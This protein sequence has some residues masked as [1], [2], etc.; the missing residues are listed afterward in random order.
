MNTELAKAYSQIILAHEDWLMKRILK[1]AKKQGYAKYTSTLEEAW[2][3]SIQEMSAVISKNIDLDIETLELRPEDRFED[4]DAA[5]FGILEADRHR[6]RGTPLTMFLAFYKYYLQTYL[7]MVYTLDLP[8]EQEQDFTLRITRIFDKIE[9]GYLHK[10]TSLTDESAIV[11]LQESSLKLTNEKNMF[12]TLVESIQAPV[13]YLDETRQIKFMNSHAPEL[14]GGKA[15]LAGAHYVN[16]VIKHTIPEWLS[17][18]LKQ[19]KKSKETELNFE[20]EIHSQGSVCHFL[21]QI[22]KM[23]DVSGKFQ[24]YS[25]FAQDITDRKAAELH[26]LENEKTVSEIIQNML[27]GYLSIDL[28]GIITRVNASTCRLMGY[29]EE[30]MLGKR[31]RDIFYSDDEADRVGKELIDHGTLQDFKSEFKRK[32]GEVRSGESNFRLVMD[33]NGEPHHLESTF[34]DITERIQIE[35]ALLESKERLSLATSAGGIGIWDYD[36]VTGSVLWDRAMYRLYGLEPDDFAG[37]DEAWDNSVHP[38]D[39]KRADAAVQTSIKHGTKHDEEFRVIWPDGSIRVLHTHADVIKD[40]NG[41]S[42]RLL[43]VTWDITSVKDAERALSNKNALLNTAEKIGFVG[44]WEWTLATNEVFYSDNALK[45][46]GVHPDDYNG[47]MESI[48]N[49]VHP[50][51]QARLSASI[52]KMVTEKKS[53]RNEY[54]VIHK[55]GSIRVLIS[56]SILIFDSQGEVERLIGHIQDITEQKKATED[57]QRALDDRKKFFSILG[58]DLRGPMG[59]IVGLLEIVNEDFETMSSEEMKDIVGSVYESAENTQRLIHTL[60]DWSRVTE[61]RMTPDRVQFPVHKLVRDSI[62]DCRDQADAKSMVLTQEVP[63]KLVVTGDYAML[64]TA[65]RNLISNAIKFSFPEASIEI[66][67]QQGSKTIALS[68]VDHGK[69]MDA[70]TRETLFNPSKVKKNV[71]TSGE[72]GTGLGLSLSNEFIKLH[73]GEVHVK[74]EIDKGSTFSILLPV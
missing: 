39:R 7:D 73:G 15:L 20:H 37:P 50:D 40:V 10:W 69:G 54:R 48:F 44:S 56:S 32:D 31:A 43:G 49:V 26:A 29:S 38:E 42:I 55:D 51:D 53:V 21:V 28:D 59:A 17:S 16:G 1:Y 11:E 19:L 25:V 18:A 33:E 66:K 67:A 3:M 24:G 70:A 68:V 65:L 60:L 62:L 9:L 64:N 34:R 5:R 12:L 74:S 52:E 2:R 14:I 8:R 41:K 23:Q 13:L 63:L 6:K 61:G 4:D 27:E 35:A 22:G 45:L 57:L 58:H 46:Y 47:Q 30:E 36:L 71:G 72:K